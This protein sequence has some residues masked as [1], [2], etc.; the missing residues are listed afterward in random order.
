MTLGLRHW[1]GPGQG[2]CARSAP[3]FS[4]LHFK[5]SLCP[6][7]TGE[8]HPRRDYISPPPRGVLHPSGIAHHAR[9]LP[10]STLGLGMC[11]FLIDLLPWDTLLWSPPLGHC[12][13]HLL[14]LSPW[15][16]S[17]GTSR[18]GPQV[19]SCLLTFSPLPQEALLV[20]QPPNH[21]P[22]APARPISALSSQ[23]S[24]SL[25]SPPGY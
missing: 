12:R 20:P 21:P 22:V 23:P 17:G 8:P 7:P 10:A 4:S 6:P 3:G 9:P 19:P 15:L 25:P 11:P 18:A 1:T 24:C 14:S 5:L 13:L 16:M 2:T